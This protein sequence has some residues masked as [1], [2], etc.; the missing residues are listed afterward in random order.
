M[1]APLFVIFAASGVAPLGKGIL[2]Y[3]WAGME[4]MVGIKWVLA[5]G[6]MYLLGLVPF[7]VRTDSSSLTYQQID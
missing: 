1:I 5:Q 3:G 7:V 2:L 4:E 6:G